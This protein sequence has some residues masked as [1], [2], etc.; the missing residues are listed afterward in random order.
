MIMTFRLVLLFSGFM[1]LSSFVQ[2]AGT[3][4]KLLGKKKEVD[5]EKIVERHNYYRAQHDIPPLEW[6][7][8]LAAYAQKWADELASNCRMYHSD[9]EYGEN[10]Y[11]TTKRTSEDEVVDFWAKEEQ[12][13]DH[14]NPIYHKHKGKKYGHYSQVIWAETKKVG[15]GMAQCDD[16]HQIWVCSYDPAGNWIGEKVY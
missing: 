1:M 4:L 5:K 7:D 16:G 2:E 15:C 12:Y 8:E 10:I 9:G 6:S 11:W 14:A 3:N 13:F